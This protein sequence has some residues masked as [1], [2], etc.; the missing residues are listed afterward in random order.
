MGYRAIFPFAH[1]SL[2]A[3][4]TSYFSLQLPMDSSFLTIKRE[5]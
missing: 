1:S 3:E 2:E 4:A 5:V